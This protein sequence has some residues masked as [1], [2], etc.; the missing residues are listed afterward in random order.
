M[1]TRRD[2]QIRA[3]LQ[4]R[5]AKAKK[6][7]DEAHERVEADFWRAVQAELGSYHGAQTDA[8]EALGY[9]RDHILKSV[10]KYVK[11]TP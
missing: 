1:S 4:S 10:K 8:A 3:A 2:P 11:K 9:T 7:R 6:E 5:V